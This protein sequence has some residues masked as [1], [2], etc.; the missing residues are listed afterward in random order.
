MNF[1]LGC[2]FIPR[3][4]ILYSLVEDYLYYRLYFYFYGLFFRFL[5]YN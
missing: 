3:L 1:T 2:L 4:D 5:T